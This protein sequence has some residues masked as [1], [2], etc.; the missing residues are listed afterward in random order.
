MVKYFISV[1]DLVKWNTEIVKLLLPLLSLAILF[2]FFTIHEYQKNRNHTLISYKTIYISKQQCVA[3]SACLSFMFVC[4]CV[5]V[6]AY[7]CVRILVMSFSDFD[8]CGSTQNSLHCDDI[9]LISVDI[10]TFLFAVS[11][12]VF[13]CPLSL[14]HPLLFTLSFSCSLLLCPSSALEFRD[15]SDNPDC[16]VLL[17]YI[18][19]ERFWNGS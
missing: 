12:S 16:L 11:L 2:Y 18:Y 13:S 3:A 1:L 14:P 5:N 6:C 17:D 15:H 19:K 9:T 10:F 8:G 7:V 4:V